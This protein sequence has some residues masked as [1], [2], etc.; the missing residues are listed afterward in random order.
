MGIE[1][2]KISNGFALGFGDMAVQ[3]FNSP[4]P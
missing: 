2:R 4:I 1:S 3:E